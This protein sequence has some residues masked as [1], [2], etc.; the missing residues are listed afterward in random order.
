MAKHDLREMLKD[1]HAHFYMLKGNEA[2]RLRM[3]DI[4][5]DSVIVDVPK[6]APLRKTILGFIP[7]L[8]GSSIYEVE[9]TVSHEYL[10]DQM[11]NTIRVVVKPGDI[12][13]VN[14]RLFPRHSFTPPLAADVKEKEGS[15]V[16]KA[17]IINMS[18][19]GLRVEVARRLLPDKDY[20]FEFDIELDDEVHSLRLAG[21][22][23][24]EIPLKDGFAYGVRFAYEEA[25]DGGEVSVTNLDATVDLLGLVNKLIVKGSEED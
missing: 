5:E 25:S 2:E 7:T 17:R 18:A 21:N 13:K 19:G 16:E 8:L 15:A 12:R 20:S 23:V 3:W 4:R 22:I 11:E 6:N 10:E 9:G 1:A 24:Y 14:R